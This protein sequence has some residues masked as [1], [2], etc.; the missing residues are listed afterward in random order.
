MTQR[1]TE[2]TTLVLPPGANPALGMADTTILMAA[3]KALVAQVRKHNDLH[4]RQPVDHDQ[5]WERMDLDKGMSLCVFH[6]RSA[7]VIINGRTLPYALRLNGDTDALR[8]A[9]QA[10]R[11][12][13][14]EQALQPWWCAPATVQP[15]TWPEHAILPSWLPCKSITP[16]DDQDRFFWLAN[17]LGEAAQSDII[18]SVSLCA[19]F[20]HTTSRFVPPRIN[21]SPPWRATPAAVAQAQRVQAIADRLDLYAIF[22]STMAWIDQRIVRVG[23]QTRIEHNDVFQSVLD[24]HAVSS[25]TAMRAHQAIAPFMRA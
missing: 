22:G 11:H 16:P 12:A 23:A 14:T 24:S 3:H 15:S 20:M 9:G 17:R 13:W 2:P 6:D 25:H 21:C 10:L 7:L 1:C 18:G 4:L 5:W 8:N 19:G